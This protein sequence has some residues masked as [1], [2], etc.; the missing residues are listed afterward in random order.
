VTADATLT[1][2]LQGE[3]VRAN[4]L[5]FPGADLFKLYSTHGLPLGD[6][7]RLGRESGFTLDMP[8]LVSAAKAAG[9]SEE[10]A[11]ATLREAYADGL[12]YSEASLALVSA[13]VQ[14]IWRHYP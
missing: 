1:N 9:W 11:V 10:R 13:M 7:L 6:A 2:A 12:G 3:A 8:G 5:R 14:R 4:A